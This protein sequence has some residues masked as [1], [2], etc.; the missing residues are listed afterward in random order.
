MVLATL[1]QAKPVPGLKPLDPP[2]TWDAVP[3][4]SPMCKELAPN[5]IKIRTDLNTQVFQD[6]YYKD[7]T[8]MVSSYQ[9]NEKLYLDSIDFASTCGI[10]YCNKEYGLA[11][12]DTVH[13]ESPKGTG[14]YFTSFT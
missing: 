13:V 5:T 6:T 2:P 7:S 12:R 8:I 10:A 1:S 14:E 4:T 11:K 3:V 9:Y